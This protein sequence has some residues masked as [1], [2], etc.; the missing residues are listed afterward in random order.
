ML[1]GGHKGPGA[2]PEAEAW[3]DG[4]TPLSRWK[5]GRLALVFTRRADV[6]LGR[7]AVGGLLTA[8]LV[9]AGVYYYAV[10]EY[11]RVGYAPTQPVPFSHAQHVGQLGL[12]CRY[13]H[14]HVEEAPHANVPATQTCMN[15]HS[16]VKTASPLLAAV[17][18]S[19]EGGD[20]VPWQRVHKV[21]GYVYFNHAVHV[22]RGVGCASCHGQLNEMAVVQHAKPLSMGWCLKCHSDPR[23]NL[24]PLIEVTS[25]SWP[26]TATE[27]PGYP[28]QR[29]EATVARL[30]RAIG[31]ERDPHAVGERLEKQ[32]RVE[33]PRQCGGCHR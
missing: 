12:D 9:L 7:A 27:F 19:Y 11:T 10:P 15:C 18:E 1:R 28:D 30:E 22:R 4:A 24:R 6:V 3:G 2:A 26:R 20:P 33:P 31:T 25:M 5:G 16:L 8:G 17:R 23:E 14:T 13:C 32:L 21:P 29:P